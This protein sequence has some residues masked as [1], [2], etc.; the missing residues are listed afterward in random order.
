MD[1]YIRALRRESVAEGKQLALEDMN[2]IIS[3]LNRSEESAVGTATGIWNTYDEEKERTSLI[4]LFE[5]IQRLLA[6]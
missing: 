3:T 4:H 1:T 2:E 6:P 5:N